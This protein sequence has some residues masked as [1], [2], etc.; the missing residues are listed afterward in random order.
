MS[1]HRKVSAFIFVAE[2]IK[3]KKRWISS[4]FRRLY[5]PADALF[6]APGCSFR[7]AGEAW[8]PPLLHRPTKQP[9]MALPWRAN[10]CHSAAHLPTS[11]ATTHDK[12]PLAPIRQRKDD[13][14]KGKEAK[15][16]E[17]TVSRRNIP[18]QNLYRDE[19]TISNLEIN[20]TTATKQCSVASYLYCKIT[21]KNRTNQ[22]YI[23]LSL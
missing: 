11:S 5:S 6:F 22:I 21:D 7:A 12:R 4:P 1:T 14:A 8:P 23:P 10:L 9:R 17:W 3:R 13:G 19:K 20:G 16:W 15:K 2:G 18:S